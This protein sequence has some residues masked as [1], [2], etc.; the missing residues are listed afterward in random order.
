MILSK[1]G[2]VKSTLAFLENLEVY[3]R[4]FSTI[5]IGSLTVLISRTA[6]IAYFNSKD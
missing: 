2:D 4:R 6:V 1:K 3:C 5:P